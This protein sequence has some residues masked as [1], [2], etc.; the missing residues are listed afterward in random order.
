MGRAGTIERII[1]KGQLVP[2]TFTKTAVAASS[3]AVAMNVMDTNADVV[4]YVMPFDFEVVAVTTSLTTARSAGTLTADVTI[5]TNA[6]GFQ[7]VISTNV[8]RSRNTSRRG[9]KVGAAGSRVGVKL[10]TDANF[11]PVTTNDV[12]VTVWVLVHLEGI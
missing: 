9:V 1:S 6:T 3:S 5:D 4:E 8:A 11:A 10:T 7:N 12:L 2:I